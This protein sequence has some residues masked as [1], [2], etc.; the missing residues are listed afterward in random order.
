MVSCKDVIA[1]QHVL[2]FPCK[3]LVSDKTESGVRE[4]WRITGGGF[5]FHQ[6][7]R[8]QFLEISFVEWKNVFQNFWKENTLRDLP[9]FS[10]L[11]NGNFCAIRC[12]GISGISGIVENSTI[13]RLSERYIPLS[14]TFWP[15]PCKNCLWKLWVK[16]SRKRMFSVRQW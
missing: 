1:M 10:K 8:F 15:T 11:N 14:G 16:R 7:L 4:R 12:S 2:I 3:L 6:K 13:F 5:P 9:K